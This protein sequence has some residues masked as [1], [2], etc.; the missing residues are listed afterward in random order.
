MKDALAE[1]LLAHVLAWEPEDMARERPLLQA[2]AAYKYD[3]YQQF[4][5]GMR[6]IE[7]LARWLARFETSDERH[8][9]YEFVKTRLIF[10]SADEVTHLVE[11][12]YPD[13]VRPFLIRR[14]ADELGVNPYH[15]TKIT[16]S[17][18]FRLLQR[19]C[20]FLGLSDGARIADFRRANRELNNEQIWQTHELSEAR[21]KGLL[22][23]LASHAAQLAGA[24]A[25]P[26]CPKFRTVVLLDDFTASGT[27][28][29]RPDKD[30]P[31]G[32]IASFHHAVTEGVL[33]QI[34]DGRIDVIVLLYMATEAAKSYLEGHLDTLGRQSPVAYHVEAVQKFSDSI[35]LRQGG[36]GPI[37][38]LIDRYYDHSVFDEH[39]EKG[40]TEHA[41]Y[42]YAAGGLPVVLHH[43]TP[44]NSIALLWSYDD[45]DVVGLF[46]RVQRH[47]EAP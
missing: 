22:K 33:S 29:Y 43:N 9:A 46:P 8:A 10:C 38:G 47:K 44:N 3:G 36:G 11:M 42:G 13:H 25:P 34:V 18:E 19:E 26:A 28:Y 32:K 39:F 7:S 15:V 14:A 41:K 17:P 23:K 31:A 1:K 2:L 20:L 37:H 45:R 16:N 4:F 5:P 27:S 30:G 40:G 35:R 12:A 24:G 21:A 6:F